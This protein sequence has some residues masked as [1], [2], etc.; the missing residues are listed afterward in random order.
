M[1][2]FGSPL[3]PARRDQHAEPVDDRYD[4][5]VPA[6]SPVLSDDASLRTERSLKHAAWR[7][8]IA[9]RTGLYRFGPGGPDGTF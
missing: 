7:T 8:E 4:N 2:H 6:E 3:R 5:D 9:R 1:E